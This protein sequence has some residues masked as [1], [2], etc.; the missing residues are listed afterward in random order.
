MTAVLLSEWTKLRSLRSTYATMLIA[1]VTA[2]GGSG[3]LEF[4]QAQAP[5]G[6]AGPFDPV[7][8]IFA[9]WLVY[10]ALAIGI[11]GVLTLTAEYST[12]QIRITFTSV[13]HRVS[14]LAAK[15][16]VTGLAGLV[17]GEALAFTA[18]GL[19]LAIMAGRPQE[20]VLSGASLHVLAG[21]LSL[22]AVIL[23]GLGLGGIFR[24]TAGAIVAL[25]AVLYLPLLVFVL[26]SSWKDS[27]GQFTLVSG[28]YQL[29]AVH[30]SAQLLSPPLSLLVVLAWPAA[31]LIVAAL[32]MT[33]RDA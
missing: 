1:A 32:V 24:N 14:V 16:A 4:A 23:I 29:V 26:P 11:L 3:I 31:V 18:Y 2:L 21:G 6:A 10:P 33:S 12:G 25:P 30:R 15:A 17:L 5:A 27:I 19:T 13:P 28:I 22:A 20:A 8:G 7:T 9:A